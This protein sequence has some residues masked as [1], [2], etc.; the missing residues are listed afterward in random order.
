MLYFF[1]IKKKNYFVFFC[2]HEVVC[3][4]SCRPSSENRRSNFMAPHDDTGHIHER[5][6][7]RGISKTCP[8]ATYSIFHHIPQHVPFLLL[9]A[10]CCINIFFTWIVFSQIRI[11][12]RELRC[13][14][15][16]VRLFNCSLLLFHHVSHRIS[17]NLVIHRL[18][19]VFCVKIGV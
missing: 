18:V 17:I 10:S 9:S 4:D 12:F 11:R 2:R 3:P 8:S 1:Q 13:W 14:L 16:K 19:S 7:S 5:K 15:A 6:K